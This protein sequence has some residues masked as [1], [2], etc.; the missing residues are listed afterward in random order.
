[1]SAEYIVAVSALVPRGRWTT[2]QEVGEVV[3]G[4]R[5]GGQ[6][7]GTALREEGHED[8]AHRTLQQGGR[9]SPSW[10][11]EGGGPKECIR[12]LRAEGVWDD[13]RNRARPERFVDAAE[14]REQGA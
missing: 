8:S 14:L 2:Y 13:S 5:R 1:M 7:V 9:V 6:P 3:Y 10:Q 12:R 11:G 4:H